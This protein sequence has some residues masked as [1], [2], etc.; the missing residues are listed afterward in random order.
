MR[1]RVESYSGYRSNERPIKFWIDEVLFFVESI[2]D[3]WSGV[4]ATYFRIRAD[5]GNTYVLSHTET[6]DAWS[7]EKST[8]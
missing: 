2:E 5:D 7:L 8:R 4:E 1:I 6:D 3:Q